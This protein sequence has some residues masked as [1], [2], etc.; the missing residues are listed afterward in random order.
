M[1]KL[2]NLIYTPTENW[3]DDNKLAL[4]EL[5]GSGGGRYPS[6]AKE[7]IKLRAPKMNTE[8]GVSYAAYIH[9]SNPDVGPYGGMCFVIFPVENAPCLV[10]MGIGTQGLS[11]DESILSRPGHT[12]KIAAITDWMNKKLQRKWFDCVDKARSNQ[13]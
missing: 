1:Q 13:N 2:I 11:P 4:E 9:P 8:D 6:R 5:F 12:R 10:A 3:T 7:T